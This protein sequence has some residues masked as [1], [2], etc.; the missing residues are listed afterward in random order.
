MCFGVILW[1]AL[2]V[3]S[4]HAH[5]GEW[6]GQILDAIYLPVFRYGCAAGRLVFRDAAPHSTGWYLIPLFGAAAQ[7]V[8]L[9]VD[10]YI[11][12]RVYRMSNPMPVQRDVLHTQKRGTTSKTTRLQWEQEPGYTPSNSS[13]KGVLSTIDFERFKWRTW[14]RFRD[15]TGHW[16]VVTISFHYLAL[17]ALLLAIVY[18]FLLKDQRDWSAGYSIFVAIIGG[19]A[20]G[21]VLIVGERLTRRLDW[22]LFARD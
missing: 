15:S 9:I 14:R 3:V 12:I 13:G 5:E 18:F 4:T 10:C 1:I 22:K 11:G 17:I 8:L 19:L 2:G 6:A 21:V 7:L 20:Y 16:P